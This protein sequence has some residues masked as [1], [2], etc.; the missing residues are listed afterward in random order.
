MTKIWISPTQT[1]RGLAALALSSSVCIVACGKAGAPLPPV[2]LT[3]E[4][5]SE[6]RLAQRGDGIELTCRA[7]RVSVDGQRLGVLDIELLLTTDEPDLTKATPL[8]RRMA[9]GER[10]VENIGPLPVAGSVLRAAARTRIKKR[11]SDLTEVVTLEVH[12][13]VSPPVDFTAKRVGGGARL[14]WSGSADGLGGVLYWVYR[15][16]PSNEYAAPI[17]ADPIAATSFVDEGSEAAGANCYVVRAV[18]SVEPPVESAI[19]SEQCVEAKSAG[20]LPEPQALLAVSGPG[21]IELS[22]SCSAPAVITGYRVYRSIGEQSPEL[23]A[24]IPAARC[25]YRD[26][27][28]PAGAAATYTVTSVDALGHESPAASSGTLRPRAR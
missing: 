18:A 12:K 7:P 20:P 4:A 22:W 5:P 23:R 17:Q 24:E 9:P 19:S 14:R 3:P 13:R 28:L 16:G 11:V 21:G 2:R 6:L 25:S 10:V 8:V 27:D 26:L 1:A 15:R